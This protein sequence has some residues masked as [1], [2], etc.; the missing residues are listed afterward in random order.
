[1]V[2]KERGSIL[3]FHCFFVCKS[4]FIFPH[5]CNICLWWTCLTGAARGHLT[6]G[7][8]AGVRPCNRTAL[9]WL[10]HGCLTCLTRWFASPNYCTGRHAMH[11]SLIQYIIIPSRKLILSW[12]MNA[13]IIIID[14]VSSVTTLTCIVLHIYDFLCTFSPCFDEQVQYIA[15]MFITV[16]N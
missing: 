7:L 6:P 13:V 12:M 14:S 5:M 2:V 1:M 9:T 4:Q 11:S 3:Y 16:A 10:G 8:N 15:I